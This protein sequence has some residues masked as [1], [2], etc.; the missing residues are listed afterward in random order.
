MYFLFRTLKGCGFGIGLVSLTAF[1]FGTAA[2]A[3]QA[4]Q[5]SPTTAGE[6]L[7]VPATTLFPGDHKAPPVDPNAQKYE[8]DAK[9]IA[10]GAKLFNWMNCSGC[11]FHGAGGMGPA[12]FNDGHFIYGGRLDQIYASIA[13]GRPNGM[14]SWAQT[15][16]QEQIWQ[17]AAYVKSLSTSNP[18]P[19]MPPDTSTESKV[20]PAP[21]GSANP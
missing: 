21:E 2:V 9:A 16:S 11:H 15:L 13:Q 3:A 14:P 17:L 5:P 6:P 18:Q 10:E 8:N 4:P 1:G 7:S 12:F 20:A 19:V